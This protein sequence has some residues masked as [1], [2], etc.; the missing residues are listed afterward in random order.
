MFVDVDNSLST[1]QTAT[2][3]Q[4]VV[5]GDDLRRGPENVACCTLFVGTAGHVEVLTADGDTVTFTN[6]P[7]GTHLPIQ[8]RRV[9][10]LAGGAADV[11]ALY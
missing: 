6:V 1:R 4:A 2:G 7:S 9:I 5:V 11:I 3:A 10:S 8:V